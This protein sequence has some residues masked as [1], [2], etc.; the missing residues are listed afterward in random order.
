DV[1]VQSC[2][3]GVTHV[4]TPVAGPNG[5]IVPSTPQIVNEGDTIA[6]TVT[7]NSGFSIANVTGCGGSL[8][9][10]TYTTAPITADCEV[11]ATFAA[12]PDVTISIDDG[13]AF[14]QYGMTLDY[15]IT[16]TN[17]GTSPA[18]GVSISNA[19]PAE[20][21]V[22]AATWVCHGGA[23]ATCTASGTGALTDSG[24]VV[25]ASGTLSYTLTAPVRTDTSSGSANN[26]V[27]VNGPSGSHSANDQDALVIMRAG[28]E[29]GD[30]G[31]NAPP[32]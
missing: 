27:T 20:L 25:P 11:D 21:D 26:Q 31:G 1:K 2:A 32:H 19:F 15:E 28:F 14:A 9:G 4:V 23:G 16:L 7:P 3:G 6:F 30:D 13:R 18:S 29:T 17:A 8:A 10:N 22:G 12:I 24:V 5:T